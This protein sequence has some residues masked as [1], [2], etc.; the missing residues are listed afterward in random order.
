LE[1][2]WLKSE[3]GLELSPDKIQRISKMDD[4]SNLSDLAELGRLAAAKLVKPEHLPA[5]F[6]LP[7]ERT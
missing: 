6:D 5:A 4:P 1:Q 7:R 3:L 2:D